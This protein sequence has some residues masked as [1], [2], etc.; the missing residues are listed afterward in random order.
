MAN[1]LIHTCAKRKWYVEDFL[2]PS[3][4]EQGCENISV[5]IDYNGDGNLTSLIKSYKL[6]RDKDTWHLQDDVIICSKFK[7][8]TEA[9]NEDV[10]CGFCNG[11]S[12]AQPG[13]TNVYSMWYSMPCIRISGDIFKHFISWLNDAGVRKKYCHFFSESKHDDVLFQYFMQENYNKTPVLNLAPN[14]VNHIDHLIGGSLINK[15]RDKE[16]SYVMAK[17]WDEPELVVDIEQRLRKGGHTNET[18]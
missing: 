4:I 1:Y 14:L 17:Y 11:F 16:L 9:H 7:E 5:Y 13:I 12:S 18:D 8:I 15:A 3:M 2:I 10:V 6:A